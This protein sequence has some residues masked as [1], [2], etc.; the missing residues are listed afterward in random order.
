MMGYM[1]KILSFFQKKNYTIGKYSYGNPKVLSWTNKYSVSIG[2]FCSIASGVVIIVDGNHRVDWIST[3]PFGELIEE[4]PK[5][6]G[7][8]VGK[9][10]IIIGNDVWIG[11]N[12]I[13]LPGVKIGDGAVI[14][15]GSVVT[16]DV[17]DYEIVAGNPIKHIKYRFAPDEIETLKSTRWWDWPK[18]MIIEHAE[19]LQTKNIEELRKLNDKYR[20]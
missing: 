2:K 13:I 19:I 9:G 17:Q 1:S 6:A 20:R 4:I 3:Y 16:R 15:A 14:G 18:E 5:N 11:L 12:T 10:D 7:H 8:P